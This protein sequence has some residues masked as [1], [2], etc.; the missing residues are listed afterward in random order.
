MPNLF[1]EHWTN[2]KYHTININNHFDI[3]LCDQVCQSLATGR[4]FSPETPVASTYKTDRQDITE[5]LLH[6][7]LNT[8]NESTNLNQFNS[9]R[10]R[11]MAFGIQIRPGL[12]QVNKMAGLDCNIYFNRL[13]DYLKCGH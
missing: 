6:V 13:F 8:I 4:W 12:G 10:A 9:K 7:T 2:I 11:N 5:I 1:R 3:S